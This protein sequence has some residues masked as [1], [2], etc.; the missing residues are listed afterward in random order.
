MPCDKKGLIIERKYPK[1]HLRCLLWTFLPIFSWNLLTRLLHTPL[2]IKTDT[3]STGSRGGH[4]RSHISDWVGTF[5]LN[6]TTWWQSGSLMEAG[7]RV[8]HSENHAK[9]QHLFGTQRVSSSFVVR[10]YIVDRSPLP[11]SILRRRSKKLNFNPF[12]SFLSVA[13]RALT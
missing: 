5:G 7:A 12:G 11:L 10:L 1:F 9:H 4:C 8:Q 2:Y 13:I 6:S 3:L